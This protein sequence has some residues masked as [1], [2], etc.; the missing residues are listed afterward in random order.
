MDETSQ[1]YR[2]DVVS[3]ENPTGMSSI[4]VFSDHTTVHK[5]RTGLN[6]V[7]TLTNLQQDMINKIQGFGSDS[8]CWSYLLLLLHRN[9]LSSDVRSFSKIQMFAVFNVRYGFKPTSHECELIY[10]EV[11]QNFFHDVNFNPLNETR[12]LFIQEDQVKI[13]NH[14]GC[15][16]Y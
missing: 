6:V 4:S 1:L 2:K 8:S 10:I 14:E 13:K 15:I 9:T 5:N 7:S 3:V 12:C 16:H 11:E